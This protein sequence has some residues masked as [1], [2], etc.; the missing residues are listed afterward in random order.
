MDKEFAVH[1]R[2]D[3]DFEA[4][5]NILGLAD[6]AGAYEWAGVAT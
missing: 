5:S 1:R 4:L 6:P 2:R 3:V